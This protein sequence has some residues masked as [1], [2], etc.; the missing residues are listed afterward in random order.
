[1]SGED[2]P[3]LWIQGR[4]KEIS[5][6]YT[7]YPYENRY[8]SEVCAMDY[9][10]WNAIAYEVTDWMI[11]A[12]PRWEYNRIVKMIRSHSFVD[13]VEWRT[14]RTMAKVDAQIGD[15]NLN[16]GMPDPIT[17]EFIEED[18]ETGTVI[19]YTLQISAPWHADKDN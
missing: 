2:L 15:L 6:Y 17:R 11:H 10:V 7:E 3:F 18:P 14:E 19:G 9:N 13:W 12:D 16:E 8:V 5:I 1:L 4:V